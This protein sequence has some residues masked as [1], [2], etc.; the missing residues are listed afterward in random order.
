MIEGPNVKTVKKAYVAIQERDI[1]RLLEFLTDDVE[2]FSIGPPE[3]IPIAG[4]RKGR[5]EV[6]EF[7]DTLEAIE[8]VQRFRPQYFVAFGSMV[9]VLGNLQSRIRST[10][11]LI[12]SPWL[13]V[14]TLR[15]GKISD[16]RSFYDTSI[17]CESAAE[18]EGRQRSNSSSL[19]SL[20]Q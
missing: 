15:R 10:G 16:F 20:T 11:N 5:R 1:P 4:R 2:W 6:E 17:F 3:L 18:E 9:V 19:I 14:F 7:L 13:N 8:E 12:N